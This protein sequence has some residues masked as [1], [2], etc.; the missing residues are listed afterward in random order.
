MISY[1]KMDNS[2]QLTNSTT[3]TFSSSVFSG[4]KLGRTIGF[5]TLNL[6]PAV[7]PFTN[8]PGVYACLVFFAPPNQKASPH[9]KAKKDAVAHLGALYFGPRLVKNEQHNVLEVFL[10]DF[11]QEVYGQTALVE[12]KDFIRPP[13]NFSSFEE[14]KA[15]LENDIQQV[16]KA[17]A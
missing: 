6:N 2:R 8:K 10:L 16:R 5:P 7:F 12:L 3:T 14:M 17:L 4:Q 15:Q 13:L 1:P 11:N 9:S